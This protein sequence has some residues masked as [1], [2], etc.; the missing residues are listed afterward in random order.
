MACREEQRL[1][2]QVKRL[3]VS[4]RKGA[5]FIVAIRESGLNCSV[6]KAHTLLQVYAPENQLNELI[7]LIKW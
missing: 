5:T 1:R 4:I 2:T 3:I 6:N 7:R